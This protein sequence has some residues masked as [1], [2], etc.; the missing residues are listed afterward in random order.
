MLQIIRDE[1]ENL[2]P[3]EKTSDGDIY[4]I[5]STPSTQV[6]NADR[7][8]DE[9]GESE[10][11]ESGGDIRQAIIVGINEIV[12]ELESGSLNISEKAIEQV[13]SNEIILTHGSSQ[14]VS[15]FL[16]AAAKKR[17]FTLIIVES[18]PSGVQAA[19]DMAKSI[20]LAAPSIQVVVVPDSAVFAVMSRGE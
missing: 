20:A 13:H 2:H 8:S 6:L 7:L 18:F 12:D 15:A 14:T 3:E 19:H 11:E 16:R 1:H 4:S 10:E 17:T 9:E 5:F